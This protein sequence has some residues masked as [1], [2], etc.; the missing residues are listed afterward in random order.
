[1]EEVKIYHNNR[2]SK[3]RETLKILNGVENIKV[4]VLNYLVNPPSKFELEKIISL[5]NISSIDLIRKNEKEY[6]TLVETYGKPT[7]N[8][9]IDWMIQFPKIMQR[10]IVVYKNKAVIGRPPE[11]VLDLF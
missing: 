10:P 5:L 1:M 6:K 4:E 8:Q 9:A 2:C 11:K 7:E 3:S